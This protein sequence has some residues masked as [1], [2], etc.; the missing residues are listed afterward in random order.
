M[1]EIIQCS[2]CGSNST[3]KISAGQYK[4]NYC[5]ITFSVVE[6]QTESN[7]IDLSEFI[8]KNQLTRNEVINA[9]QKVKPILIIISVVISLFTAGI[10]TAVFLR[11]KPLNETNFFNNKWQ[12]P[13]L[14]KYAAYVGTNGSVIWLIYKQQTN[15]LDSAKYTLRII[16]PIT[17]QTIKEV[18]LA[19]MQWKNAFNWYKQFDYNFFPVKD[20]LYAVSEINGLQGYNMYTGKL[21]IDKTTLQ[22]DFTE[23]KSGIIEVKNE[24][25]KGRCVITNKEGDDYFYIFGLNSIQSSNEVNRRKEY[26]NDWREQIYATQTKKSK[27]YLINVSNNYFNGMYIQNYVVEDNLISN[28]SKY[29]KNVKPLNDIIYPKAQPILRT[30]SNIVFF[31]ATDFSK[32]AKGVLEYINNNG[33]SKW[34]LSDTLFNHLIKSSATDNFYLDFNYYGQTL[35][36]NFSD[37][38]YYSV[39]VNIIT[40]K[41]LYINSQTNNIE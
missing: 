9:K 2:S 18:V 39:G 14:E 5:Q 30:D 15:T 25:Y 11:N 26:G 40:G 1:K 23:L 27:L 6:N 10:A 41:L 24:A 3:F 12:A 29:Y 22:T 19:A 36:I 37:A 20:I 28:S 35:V 34:Q 31:Y 38:N 4:C 8:K 13:S 33:K 17:K 7:E 16:N 32:D 21:V